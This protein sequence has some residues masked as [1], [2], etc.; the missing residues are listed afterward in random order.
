MAA[1]NI[2]TQIPTNI[3]SIERL[4]AWALLTNKA[5][6]PD[7]TFNEFAN[8]TDN[9][10]QTG[11]AECGDKTVRLIVRGAFQLNP[12]YIT[13]EDPLWMAVREISAAQI[14]AA[15]LRS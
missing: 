12:D 2:A 14:P 9:V 13:S 5:I 1:I 6:Y 3:N 15:Y 11:I 4:A 8:T 10:I 7:V